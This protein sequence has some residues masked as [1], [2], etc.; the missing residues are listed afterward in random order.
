MNLNE[1][2]KLLGA[3]PRER[4]PES[5]LA[6]PSGPE[7][8]A[9]RREAADFED[10]L[11]A[12]AAVPA[13]DD[14]LLEH[15]LAIPEQQPRR[16]SHWFAIAASV[17]VAIGAAGLLWNILRPAPSL[18]EHIAWHYALDGERLMAMASTEF[19]INKAQE[20]L[21]HFGFSA[22]A[23]LQGR[24]QFMKICPGYEGESAHMIVQTE[25]GPISIFIMPGVSGEE[26][27]FEFDGMQA[28]LVTIGDSM[29][30]II[31]R[32]EQTVSAYGNL[33]RGALTRTS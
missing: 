14:E 12:A 2:R 3:D 8:D 23:E 27:Q 15:L 30:A 18:D 9:A 10:T 26:H 33:V 20:I 22:T 24:I 17:V 31:G 4:E 25:G 1:F 21:A 19:D 13:P 28:Y 5:Q 32:P 11:H 6:P 16:Q 7:F 29:A